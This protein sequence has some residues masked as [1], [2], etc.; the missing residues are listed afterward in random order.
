MTG[1]RWELVSG[2]A[3]PTWS[4]NPVVNIREGALGSYN[5]KVTGDRELYKVRPVNTR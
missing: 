3:N 4:G 2:N 1:E 5:M